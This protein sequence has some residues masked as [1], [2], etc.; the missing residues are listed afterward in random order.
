MFRLRRTFAL[1]CLLSAVLVSPRH[2]FA[3]VDAD[4]DGYGSGCALGPDCNDANPGV[5]PAARDICGDGIDQDCDGNVDD[6][7]ADSSGALYCL[8]FDPIQ[9]IAGQPATITVR[10]SHQSGINRIVFVQE[11]DFLNQQQQK[12]CAPATS[13]T[14]TTSV[15][16][17]WEGERLLYTNLWKSPNSFVAERSLS[18]LFLCSAEYCPPDP[19]SS[20]FFSWMRDK[21]YPECITSKYVGW[22]IDGME[23]AILKQGLRVRPAAMAI[24]QVVDFYDVIPTDVEATYLSLG[25]G[26]GGTCQPLAAWPAWCPV[27]EVADHLFI[28]RHFRRTLGL[29]LSFRYHRTP[30]DYTQVLGQPVLVGGGYQF[31]VPFS[32][33]Q[34]FPA[35]SIVHFA[36]ESWNGAPVW[37]M[38]GASHVAEVSLEPYDAYGMINYTHEWGHTWGLPHPFYG[39]PRVFVALDG[40][41]GNTYSGHTPLIDPLDPVE[42]FSLEPPVGGYLDDATFA[43]D[44][45]AGLIGSW[46]LPACGGV[47]PL[48]EGAAVVRDAPDEVAVRLWLRDGGPAASGY[49]PLAAF[50]GQVAAGE[51]IQERVIAHMPAGTWLHD[52]TLSRSTAAT[53]WA[54]FVL[55]ADEA[56]AESN[57]TDNSRTVA[58][59][60]TFDGDGDGR[61]G[62]QGDCNDTS[63]SLWATPTETIDLL[64]TSAD[65]W[66]WS[67]PAAPGATVVSYDVLR[68]PGP[69]DFTGQATCV[70]S[71]GADLS[72]EDQASPLS[73]EA[74][75]YLVRASNMCPAGTGPLG[76]GSDGVPRAGRPCP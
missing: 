47:N 44:Y 21:G 60:S 42:R 55:D 39:T 58:L 25:A 14:F 2:A 7:I 19:A 12:I 75:F 1:S 20:A 41:M 73:G 26:E 31:P 16:Q 59:C 22:D 67:P 54:T 23:R 50:D 37:D 46:N 35:H 9:A 64:A 8:E 17:P 29:N 68:A 3:C 28:E 36:L 34:A 32:F 66:A 40:I 30:I 18:P 52:M 11:N 74:F 4:G 13:C 62:C 63:G 76:S 10:A 70:E 72:A 24:D 65:T 71:N 43:S 51:P 48:I 61:T 33:I 49:V 27:P 53:G 56:I 5:N 57:E 45:A 69:G 6:R 38:T 15:N